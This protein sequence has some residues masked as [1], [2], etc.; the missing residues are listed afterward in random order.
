[1]AG[2]WGDVIRLS[3]AKYGAG[4]DL[5]SRFGEPS[6]PEK[7]D[8]AGAQEMNP[9]SWCLV[10]REAGKDATLIVADGD[11]LEQATRVE[12]AYVRGR[13]VDLTSKHTQLWQKY[14]EKYQ[15]KANSRTAGAE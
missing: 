6:A 7:F 8:E 5:R 9:L 11:V 12:M 4:P 2:D 10:L 15:R 14:R 13:Q 1:M 3:G